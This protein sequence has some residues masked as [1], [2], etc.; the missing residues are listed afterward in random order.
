MTTF[1]IGMDEELERGT[2][3]EELGVKVENPNKLSITG[4]KWIGKDQSYRKSAPG[5][6]ITKTNVRLGFDVCKSLGDP[7]KVMVGV[8]EINGE[9]VVLITE[10][11]NG[12]TI[13]RKGTSRV[14]RSNFLPNKLASEGIERGKFTAEKRTH[15]GKPIIICRRC[16]A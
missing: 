3:E 1:K 4:V 10:N 12:H 15:N 14:I 13:G 2:L 8:A 11:K 6:T 16:E 5:M 9:K 7:E